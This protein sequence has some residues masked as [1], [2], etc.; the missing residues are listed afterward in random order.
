MT[1]RSGTWMVK[2]Y[3]VFRN[4]FRC[5]YS[6][7]ISSWFCMPSLQ[8]KTGSLF[9]CAEL[10][11]NE[12]DLHIERLHSTHIT[13]NIAEKSWRLENCSDYKLRRVGNWSTCVLLLITTYHRFTYGKYASLMEPKSYTRR[14]ARQFWT[15]KSNWSW[16]FQF[17]FLWFCDKL[18]K[19]ME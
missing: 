6:L 19:T 9:V 13:F 7:I 18:Q 5:L 14:K 8:N 1:Q 16:F 4:I 10:V 17:F 2:Y 12:A 15:K 11:C 3:H